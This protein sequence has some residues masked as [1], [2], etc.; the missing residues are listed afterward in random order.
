MALYVKS[1]DQQIHLES[2][3][4]DHPTS[5]SLRTPFSCIWCNVL[6][7]QSSKDRL[8]NVHTFQRWVFFRKLQT[9]DVLSV[10]DAPSEVFEYVFK[11]QA[12]YSSQRKSFHKLRFHITMARWLTLWQCGVWCSGKQTV[13]ETLYIYFDGLLES[14]AWSPPPLRGSNA[15]LCSWDQHGRQT[16]VWRWWWWSMGIITVCVCV[17]VKQTKVLNSLN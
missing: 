3:S 7:T 15:E 17:G 14:L 12:C 16:L 11:L 4:G 8:K 1:E 6:Y 5:I 9:S 13:C 10:F 2:S